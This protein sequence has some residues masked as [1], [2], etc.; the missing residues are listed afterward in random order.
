MRFARFL[1]KNIFQPLNMET[2]LAYERGISEVRD[3]AYGYAK[4]GGRF[5]RDDQ[6][7][8]SS[9]LGDGG[10]YSSTSDLAKWDQALYTDELVS[11]PTRELAFSGVT[12]TDIAGTEYGFGWFIGRYRGLKELW[13]YGETVGFTT[14]ISRF[15]DK[16][17]TSIILANR[18]EASIGTIP[19]LI[20]ERLL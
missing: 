11:A 17:F 20:A 15:P 2:T 8:T 7:L 6:S 3:R 1:Q 10:I 4:R 18:S 14:R 12:A 9:V 13:H 5:E 16:Q 19:H